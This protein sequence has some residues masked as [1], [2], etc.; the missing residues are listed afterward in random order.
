M[1]LEQARK[2]GTADA[3]SLRLLGRMYAILRAL[4][5]ADSVF[6]DVL[7]QRPDDVAT[8]MDQVNSLD[9]ATRPRH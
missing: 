8:M 6:R 3:G 1:L 9:P 2:A 5:D 7:R 4:Q